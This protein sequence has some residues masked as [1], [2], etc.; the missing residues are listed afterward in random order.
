MKRK[1]FVA[2][3]VLAAF[4]GSACAQ[5]VLVNASQPVLAGEPFTLQLAEL[6]PGQTVTLRAERVV[7]TFTGP[8]ALFAGEASFTADA[9]GAV[10]LA[11]QAPMPGSSYASADVRGLLWSMKKTTAPAQDL[12]GRPFGRVDL[13]LRDAGGAELARA[14][15]QLAHA[16]PTVQT[17]KAEPF[18]GAL[19]ASLPGSERRA[20]LILLGGSEGGSA[21]TRDAAHWASHGYAVLALPYYSP[22]R[23]G[24]NGPLPPEL[25]SLP[26]RFFDIPVE[27]LEAARDW[28]ARQPEADVAR[29]GV[30]G[31]SKGAEFALLA[32][33]QMPWLRAVAAIV[34]TDV[35]WEGWGQD[36]EAPA[37]GASFAWKG[38][39]YAHVR[40]HDMAAEWRKVMQGGQMRLRRPHE[41][42][43]AATP[44]EQLAQAR[45]PVERIRAALFVAGGGDDQ[46]WPSGDMAAA[47]AAR[48][49]QAGLQTTALVFPS[50]GHALGGTGTGPTTH[51]NEG[52]TALGGQ[53]QADAEAQAATHAA[54]RRFFAEAL[55]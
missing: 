51:Y 26:L 55:K 31:T 38:R 23:W 28:L 53:P 19:F 48:R 52:F 47:I 34:P 44:P 12:Q 20:T 1:S 39:P 29:I 41:E 8:V 22:P 36:P 5:R 14:E 37:T 54:L 6:Q 32:G 30:M 27:R 7:R 50:A 24:A 25:P 2:L 18:E 43:R 33:V 21:I 9:R 17:R 45:I 40:Y 10:D 16:L 3:A 11:T 13:R 4:A 42:G 15:L 46:L 49:Q 35:V